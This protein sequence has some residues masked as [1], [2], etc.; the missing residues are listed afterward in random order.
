MIPKALGIV[1]LLKIY[2]NMIKSVSETHSKIDLNTI[3]KN[4]FKTINDEW[5][6][7]TAGTP[8][9]FNTM[10]ASWGTLGIL[11]N[12]PIAICFIRPHRYTFQF[13]EKSPYFSLSFFDEKNRQILDYCGSYS[14]RDTDKVSATGLIPLQLN[15]YCVA[16]EQAVL[17]FECQKLY[18]DFI[19]KENFVVTELI[20][21]I[22]PAEDFHRFF[23]GEITNCYIQKT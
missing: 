6:L 14:G 12:K 20:K 11:W 21:K 23:I 16:F 3:Q 10:T 7:I 13:A 18:A 17:I 4:F 8:Q 9:Q 22:Y 5:M 19:K 15:D 1:I 2:Y